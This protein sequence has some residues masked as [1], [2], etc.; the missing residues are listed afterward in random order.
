MSDD[1]GTGA[2]TAGDV[3]RSTPILI[4]ALTGIA[5]LLMFS[6][7]AITFVDVVGRYA[8]DRPLG[9]AFEIIELLLGLLIFSALPLVSRKQGHITVSLLEG[10]F[11]GR[12]KWVQQLFVL[13][14]SA[15]AVGFMTWRLWAEMQTMRADQDVG[16]YMDIELWPFIGAVSALS[17]VTFIIL[18][19]LVWDYL[20]GRL[21]EDATSV[22]GDPL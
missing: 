4:R 11:Q 18:L 22:H 14:F 20:R 1:L 3:P 2:E 8:F 9:A 7:M 12:V 13:L 16:E 10:M 19:I 15:G 5:A 21:V 6:L 17:A